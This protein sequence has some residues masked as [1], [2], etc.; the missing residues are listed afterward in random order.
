MAFI[1]VLHAFV[2]IS[3]VAAYYNMYSDGVKKKEGLKADNPYEPLNAFTRN[4]FL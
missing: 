1:T 2:F 3:F 4:F